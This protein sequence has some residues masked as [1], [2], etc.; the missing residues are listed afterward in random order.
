MSKRPLRVVRAALKSRWGLGA[1][2]VLLGVVVTG[3]A[4]ASIPETCIP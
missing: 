1:L 3:V 2:C 4:Q